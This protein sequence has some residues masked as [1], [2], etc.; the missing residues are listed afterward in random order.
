MGLESYVILSEV[1][2]WDSVIICLFRMQV[3]GTEIFC[4]RT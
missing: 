4:A 1:S 2:G 3:M